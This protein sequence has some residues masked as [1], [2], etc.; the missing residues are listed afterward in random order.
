MDIMKKINVLITGA[1]APG[2][3]GTI[4]SLKKN[5]DRRE[6]NIVGTDMNV[7]AIGK[8]ACDRFY[9]V[10]SAR[11]FSRYFMS[12]REICANEEIS[13]IIPQNTMELESLASNIPLFDEINVKLLLPNAKSISIANNKYLLLEK[14]KDL[15]LPTG[16]FKLVNTYSDLKVFAE[17]LGW[18]NEKVV[19]KLPVSNGMRGLRIISESTDELGLFL[20]EKPTSTF[21]KLDYFRIL[22]QK[23][24]KELLVCEYLPGDEY[25]VDLLRTKT[26]TV[27]LPRKR[28]A[29]RSG[30]SFDTAIEKDDQIIEYSRI[31]SDSLG[32]ENCFGFQFKRNMLGVPCLLECNP[33][34]QGTMVCSV[35]ANQNIIYKGVK[36]LLGEPME[37]DEKN[38]GVRFMRY[39]GGLA[40]SDQGIEW[41]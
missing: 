4:Y 2:I 15:K 18:P 10:P 32:L 39:W 12:L 29:I 6:I 14:A 24:L 13:I 19:A 8:Y 1:G 27:I 26:Q 23:G 36:N 33:R 30:I 5:N 22:F 28:I 16:K 17:E 25:S 40:I 34:V 37:S 21:V 31:L 38:W 20:N 3:I 11:D 7:N 35:F 41:M 9:Q